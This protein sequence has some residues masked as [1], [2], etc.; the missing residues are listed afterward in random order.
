MLANK[1]L[2]VHLTISQWTGRKLDKKATE[3]VEQ[4]HN[5]K[6]KVGNYTKQ[7]LPG[8]KELENIQRLASSIRAF[9]Y[10]NTLPWY[11]DG[12]RILSAKNYLDFTNEFRTKKSD[13]DQAVNQFI[14]EYP[15]LREHAKNT[16]GDL[17]IDAEYPNPLYLSGAFNCEI[18][19]MPI[20][21]VQDFRVDLLDSEKEAF[22]NRMQEIETTATKDCWNR[23]FDVVSKAAS[24]LNQPN[25]VFRDSLIENITE[26]CALLPK[27][28]VTDDPN[29]EAMR[30]TV[31]SSIAT[32]SPD[33][34]RQS[35]FDRDNAARQLDEITSKMSAFMGAF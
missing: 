1:A 22:L 34:L 24:K 5:T 26:I 19:F 25:A 21:A 16:L 7:L 33:Q 8:A 23:L 32:Y 29:L 15:A 17:F 28:N 14:S 9:F 31:E 27:L 13:W 3:T 12:S 35:K 4:T 11:S 10:S 18:S 2:L 20:P 6:G 30:Q